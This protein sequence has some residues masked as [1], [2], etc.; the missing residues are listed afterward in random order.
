MLWGKGQ[1]QGLGWM[2]RGREEGKMMGTGED[3]GGR[4]EEDK[5]ERKGREKELLWKVYLLYSSHSLSHYSYPIAKHLKSTES[6]SKNS[7][8]LGDIG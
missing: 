3:D 4:G 8:I 5:R 7:H 6:L 1:G 2:G